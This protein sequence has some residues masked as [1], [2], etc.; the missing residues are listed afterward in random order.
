MLNVCAT[1]VDRENLLSLDNPNYP[2]IIRKYSYLQGVQMEE[3]ATKD[4][5]PIHVILGAN[6]YTKIKVAGYQKAGNVGE[7]VAEKTRFGWTIMTTGAEVNT[8]T[9]LFTQTTSSDYEELCRLD[10]LEL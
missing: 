7:P 6:E 1:K 10:V 8:Q 4:Q 3:T 2:D 5:L 9:M